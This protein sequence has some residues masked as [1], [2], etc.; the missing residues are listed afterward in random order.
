MA[1]AP[2]PGLLLQF[3]QT[4]SASFKLRRAKFKLRHQSWRHAGPAGPERPLERSS[5]LALCAARCRW[6]GGAATLATP[7]RAGC[8]A[9]AR[10]AGERL[11]AAL[12]VCT[13]PGDDRGSRVLVDAGH[14]GVC[15][16]DGCHR[17]ANRGETGY[18]FRKL[19]T[20]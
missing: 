15:R 14:R 9:R 19:T 2:F 1:V 16:V 11:V 8:A 5:R 10:A 17:Q 3:E 7:A 12:G 18:H 6:D 4:L 20:P 13:Q